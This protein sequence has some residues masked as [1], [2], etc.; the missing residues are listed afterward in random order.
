MS[1]Y[2]TLWN[3]ETFSTP[4]K[5]HAV[6][7][8]ILEFVYA[9]HHSEMAFFLENTINKSIKDTQPS[10]HLCST[11]MPCWT[12]IRGRGPGNSSSSAGSH[13]PPNCTVSKSELFLVAVISDYPTGPNPLRK[14]KNGCCEVVTC[15]RKLDEKRCWFGSQGVEAPTQGAFYSN[16]YV[17]ISTKSSR[18]HVGPRPQ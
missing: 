7:H 10:N 5:T 11:E 3:C 14:P 16:Y 15:Q 2:P 8:T 4:Q 18:L 17:N 9:Y 12:T 1:V 6:I 13:Q